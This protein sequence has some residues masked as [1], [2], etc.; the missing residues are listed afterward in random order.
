M[1]EQTGPHSGPPYDP[2]L[3]E[4][5]EGIPH[6][7]LTEMAPEH[8]EEVRAQAASAPLPEG[9]AGRRVAA[10]ELI[11]P[12]PADH[13]IALTRLRPLGAGEGSAEPAPALLWFHGGGMVM[14]NRHLGADQV[15]DWVAAHGLTAFSV[16]YRL[17]PE[18]PFP[19]AHDDGWTV[20][21]WVLEHAEDLGVDPDQVVLAGTSAGGC[22]AA[23][24][25]LRARDEGGAHGWPA[26]AGLLLASPMLDDR[27]RTPS[28]AQF[29]E[30]GPWDG[31]DS[32]Y[33]WTALLG[34]AAG[35]P[36][37]SAYAAPARALDTDPG[38]RGLP[39]T[40]VDVGSAELFRDEAVAF[41]A[42]LWEADGDAEL[43]VWAGGFHGFTLAAGSSSLADDC[44]RAQDRWLA[45]TLG[46]PSGAPS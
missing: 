3:A 22:L 26:L 38:L 32:T 5:A 40:Y 36:D 29:H 41:A 12:A 30:R 43:H 4:L 24:L 10:D 21:G 23:G 17:A 42:G 8:I 44:L 1:T 34:D 19:A 13:E 37:V 2:D 28:A 15:A 45:R 11:V 9:L 27:Q 46:R 39:L 35:G 16:E 7:A 14:G 33:A 25:A 6:R 18:H 20:L 31:R